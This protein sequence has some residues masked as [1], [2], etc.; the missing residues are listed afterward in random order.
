M[1]FDEQVE[2]FRNRPLKGRSRYLWLDART[3]PG[4]RTCSLLV[5]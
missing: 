1:W 5:L 4:R 2:A 3:F